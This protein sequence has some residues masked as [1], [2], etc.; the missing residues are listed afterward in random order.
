ME[1]QV[2]SQVENPI[3]NFPEETREAVNGLIWVGHL[4]KEVHF[5]QHTFVIRT[6]KGDEELNAAV[7]SKEYI[8][9]LGQA[10]AWA[11]ATIGLALVSIDGDT[12]F[13]PPIGPDGLQYAR[14]RF[15]YVSKNWYWPTCEHLYGEYADLLNRQVEAIRA[16]Q[17]LSEGNR[18]TSSP[19]LDS[20]TELGIS[21]P[22]MEES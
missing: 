10:K 16:V 8:E 4:E 14:A 5:C 6:L 1:S 21:I 11:W 13:C 18:A 7:V 19:L 20:L 3:D 12:T 17:D 15:H 9:T 2:E 22:E